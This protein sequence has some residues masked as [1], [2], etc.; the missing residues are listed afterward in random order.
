[1]QR[2]DEGWMAFDG[3]KST[4]TPCK[5]S[6]GSNCQRSYYS[7]YKCKALLVSG[8]QTAKR[9]S[10]TGKMCTANSPGKIAMTSTACGR[11][12]TKYRG[13]VAH[14][15]LFNWITNIAGPAIWSSQNYQAMC[16]VTR[17]NKDKYALLDCD[18]LAA[19]EQDTFTPNMDD[20]YDPYENNGSG[21]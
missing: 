7:A 17:R 9:N 4:S 1:M 12:V 19:T 2:L 13:S 14:G 6:E 11:L 16:S 18:N 8:D 3:K 15:Q 21:R 5:A 20:T 10:G